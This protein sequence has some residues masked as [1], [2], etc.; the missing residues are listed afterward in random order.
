M[1]V[2]S[3]PSQDEASGRATKRLLQGRPLPGILVDERQP[4][5]HPHTPNSHLANRYPGFRPHQRRPSQQKGDGT[6]T[7][8]ESG[9]SFSSPEGDPPLHA[10]TT[11]KAST[12]RSGTKLARSPKTKTRKRRP[13]GSVSVAG[14]GFGA[15]GGGG[16]AAAAAAS[17]VPAGLMSSTSSGVSS[18]RTSEQIHR[19][20]PHRVSRMAD[21]GRATY[22]DDPDHYSVNPDPVP[23]MPSNFIARS[24]SSTMLKKIPIPKRHQDTFTGYE[25]NFT[26]QRGVMLHTD[27]YQFEA[28]RSF[29]GLNQRDRLLAEMAYLEHLRCIKRRREV[30]PH[31]A[32]LDLFLGGK[33]IDCEERFD[34]NREIRRL[35]AMA[36]PTRAQDLFH[37]RGILL[38]PTHMSLLPHPPRGPLDESDSEDEAVRISAPAS[39]QRAPGESLALLGIQSPSP[40]ERQI[41]LTLGEEP[42]TRSII[43]G[44]R[45]NQLPSI[46]KTQTPARAEYQPP[47]RYQNFVFGLQRDDTNQSKSQSSQPNTSRSAAWV[48]EQNQLLPRP[49]G[50][51]DGADKNELFLTKPKQK[52]VVKVTSGMGTEKRLTPE[53]P[54]STSEGVAR[55]VYGS[56]QTSPQK[57]HTPNPLKAG[58]ELQGV[59]AEQAFNLRQTFQRLDT[60][61]DGHLQYHQLKSQLPKEFSQQQE[62]FVKQVYEITRS[63]AAFFGVDEF[64]MMTQLTSRVAALT[65]PAQE[66][67]GKLNFE[68]LEVAIIH[69]VDLFQSTDSSQRGRISLESLRD[70]VSKSQGKEP[71]DE[72]SPTWNTIMDSLSLDYSSQ[73]NRIEYLAHIPLFMTLAP[74]SLPPPHL[75][76]YNQ[77]QEQEQEQEPAE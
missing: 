21:H 47:E 45:F 2:T 72:N 58:V 76:E 68:T 35:K 23:F 10:S 74:P 17:A 62:D 14:G 64:L 27:R 51:E 61:M 55:P 42:R 29:D 75:Q 37:G 9:V 69:Y 3:L 66:A 13:P 36:M 18:G 12:V 50:R 43:R 16:A 44:K 5:H 77:Q 32:Q 46:S 6:S 4:P 8:C 52:E 22:I 67:Y 71:L 33:K 26:G 38:P 65:G 34:I 59:S 39:L 56:R 53:A 11:S 48:E 15:G 40:F 30:V 19:K 49:Q 63:S 54:P 41:S 31:R 28:L 57:S 73:V 7:P 1:E 60:D 70:L 25:Y 24:W 20:A